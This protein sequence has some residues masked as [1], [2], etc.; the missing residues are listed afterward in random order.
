M[1][2][3]V[4][5]T[6]LGTKQ[7]DK[8][9]QKLKSDLSRYMR[10][11]ESDA[12]VPVS[13]RMSTEERRELEAT[14]EKTRNQLI[15]LQQQAQKTGDIGE[16]AGEKSGKGFE[17]GLKSLKRFALGLFGIRTAFSGL[18]RATSAYLAENEVTANKMNAIWVALGN[19]LGPLI[20]IIANG[21]L[22]LIGYLNVFL[23]ALG[24]KIDLTKNIGKNTKAIK[25]QTKAQKELNRQTASFDEMNVMSSN[26]TASS[27]TGATSNAFT[28]PEL[29]ENIVNK[30]KDLAY[31]LK[32]NWDWIWKVGLAITGAFAIN[33]FNGAIGGLNGLLGV[34]KPLATIGVIAIGVDLLYN[35]ATGRDLIDDLRTI[36]QELIDGSKPQ[37]ERTE[38]TKA[39]VK[40]DKELIETKDKEIKAY[41]KG[42]EEANRYFDYLRTSAQQYA[43]NIK[44]TAQYVDNLSGIAYWYEEGSGKVEEYNHQLSQNNDG[45]RMNIEAMAKMYTQGQLTNQQEEKFFEILRAVNGKLVDGKVIYDD[46]DGRILNASK[47]TEKYAYL[48]EVLGNTTQTTATKMSDAMK[49]S[50]DKIAKSINDIGKLKV[51]PTVEFKANT[52]K[53]T[54]VFDT[55]IDS[56]AVDDGARGAMNATNRLLKRLGL[57]QGGIVNL[58]GRG[59]PITNVVA[60]EATGGQEGVI[61]MN[62]EQ[63]MNVLGEAIARYVNINI[64]NNTL[65]DGKVIA[66]EQKKINDNT[67]FATNGRGI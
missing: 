41:T 38:Q 33:K 54:D 16:E 11:L 23:N 10:V 55:L 24:F 22:K 47:H 14:I 29:N 7:F 50:T 48:T 53:L 59:V 34:L 52:K 44:R 32:E 4:V 25:E 64:T 26:K 8:Q 20:E 45:I 40:A 37:K 2:K 1:A 12:K 49:E 35:A 63:S 19:A 27:G 21:V 60:G 57:A 58:P 43:S 17:K 15:S 36:K 42:S 18:R 56:V 3:I 62:N 6:E 65:L 5:E 39:Q 28:M 67:N 66:R 30:L 31:W 51:T 61:P 9:I 46:L 13:L